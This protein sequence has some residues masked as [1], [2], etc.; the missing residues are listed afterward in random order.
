MMYRRLNSIIRLIQDHCV[1][2]YNHAAVFFSLHQK[3]VIENV[4]SISPF[5][6]KLQ[7]LNGHL[8]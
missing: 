8:S 4:V 6:T 1:L 2:Q 3:T 5:A 7:L